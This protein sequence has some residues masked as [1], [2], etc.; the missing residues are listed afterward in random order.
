M[1]IS[2]KQENLTKAL[3]VV[4]R[5]VPSR[6]TLPITSNVLLA[7]DQGR[8]K[9][10]AT[11]LEIS[12][13]SRIGAKVDEEGAVT[14]PA[15]MLS[16]MVN[17]LPNDRVDLELLREQQLLKVRCGRFQA[18]LKGIDADEFPLIPT[19]GEDEGISLTILTADLKTA[20]EQVGFSAAR[21]EARPVF[22]GVLLRVRDGQLT[23]V[24]CDSF[25]LSL[26]TLEVAQPPAENFDIIVPA[27]AMNDV[28]RVLN[29]EDEHVT[30][31]VTPKKSQVLFH[32]DTVDAVSRLVDGQYPD[33]PRILAQIEKHNNLA[34]INREELVQ[35]VKFASYVSR[36]ANNA[37]YMEF[38]PGPELGPGSIKLTATA[39][40]VGDNAGEVDSVI[41]GAGGVLSLDSNFLTEALNACTGQQVL[42]SFL[43]GQTVAVLVRPFGDANTTHIIMPMQIQR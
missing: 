43:H 20:I 4:S 42:M 10:A 18:N 7:S 24:A 38:T 35:A 26:R 16:D 29:V 36:E 13:T 6:S 33:Y 5:A 11:N 9:L 2:C 17:S 28:A 27:R 15:R 23:L 30:I 40:S 3:S 31:A 21:D 41:N 19:I 32:T 22:A 1:R 34:M 12:I 39:A 8:L 14:V 25:R 37:L